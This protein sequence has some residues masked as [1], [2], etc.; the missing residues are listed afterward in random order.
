[1]LDLPLS[2][3]V[4]TVCAAALVLVRLY[5]SRTHHSIAHIRGPPAKSMI[6]G[7]IRDMAYQESVG[8]LDFKYMKEYGTAW[9]LHATFGKPV[10]MISDP[11]ALQHVLHKSGYMYPKTTQSTTLAFN[12]TGR[13]IIWAP[14]G[15]IHSRHRKIMNPAFTA[16]QLRS[17]LPLFRRSSAKLCQM[18]K[19]QILSRTPEG[20]TVVVNTWLARTT[21]DVIGEAAFDFDFGALDNTDNELMKAYENMFADS[22]MYPTVWNAIFQ[23]FWD[24]LP[25]KVLEQVRHIPTRE[26]RRMQSTLRLFIKYS[27]RLIAQKSAALASDKSSKDVMSVLIRANASEDARYKLSDE[28]MESQMSIMTIAGHETTANTITWMLYELAKHPDYQDKV[29]AEIALKRAEI[30]ARGDADFSIE[31]LESLEYLQAAIKETL[32]YHC[33]VYHLNRMASQDDTIPLAYPIVSASGEMISEIPVAKGQIIMLNIAAYNRL[34][35]VWGADAHEWNPMRY[36]EDKVDPQVRVGM[37]ANLMT[38]SAGVRGCIGWRF[39]VI[40]TQAIA[41]DLIENFQFNLPEDK[42]EIIRV[43]AGIMGPMIKGREGEGMKMPLHVTAV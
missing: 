42:P 21:L 7:N 34:P 20:T 10:L 32:R 2:L 8:D 15:D 37:Y 38:F 23:A 12:I 6:M 14:N 5:R 35:E 27:Q 30:I 43:P 22:N 1:M 28:E 26:Y 9:R 36:V 3:I 29:R 39:S 19:D 13:S 24:Y 25:D 31:D 17:F 16:P 40:E 11:K 33:I 4:F 41:A 18:W